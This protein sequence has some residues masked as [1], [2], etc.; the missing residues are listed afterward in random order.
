MEK[1]EKR[2]GWEEDSERGRNVSRRGAMDICEM[3]R[4]LSSS[5]H[6]KMWVEGGQQ[7]NWSEVK[8]R[9]W[10]VPEYHAKEW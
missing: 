9:V 4:R 6:P 8:A 10:K 2:S 1:G 7:R 3:M 5:L